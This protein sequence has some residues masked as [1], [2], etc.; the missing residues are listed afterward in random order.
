VDDSELITKRKAKRFFFI[1]GKKYYVCTFE[2]HAIVAPADLRFELW[3]GG[4]KFSRNHEP[5]KVTWNEEGTK[6]RF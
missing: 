2:V 1:K 6:V 5:I 4:R 3:F